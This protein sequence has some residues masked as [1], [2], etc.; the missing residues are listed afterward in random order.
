MADLT[1]FAADCKVGASW[2]I[3]RNAGLR[4]ILHDLGVGTNRESLVILI[5]AI[6]TW[7]CFWGDLVDKDVACLCYRRADYRRR[8]ID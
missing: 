3:D 6:M 5:L 1:P 2:S 4:R 8:Y 7:W